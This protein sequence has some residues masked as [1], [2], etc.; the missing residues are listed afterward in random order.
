MSEEIL[1]C[2]RNVRFSPKAAMWVQVISALVPKRP[3]L[4]QNVFDGSVGNPTDLSGSADVCFLFIRPQVWVD[5]G[6][7]ED[8]SRSCLH[9]AAGCRHAPISIHSRS[10]EHRPSDLRQ[11]RRADVAHPRRAGRTR[12]GETYV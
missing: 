12:L 3:A 10:T 5:V 7:V 4:Q 9:L 1:Y 8:R 6:D 2:N 11:V